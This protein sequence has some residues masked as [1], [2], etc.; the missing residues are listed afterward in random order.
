MRVILFTTTKCRSC[1]KHTTDF[2]NLLEE[3]NIEY[4]I[5]DLDDEKYFYRAMENIRKYN[6]RKTPSIVILGEEGKLI[7]KIEGIRNSLEKL[8]TYL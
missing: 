6:L 1:V 4:R 7:K 5:Y 8:Q 3:K 2:S